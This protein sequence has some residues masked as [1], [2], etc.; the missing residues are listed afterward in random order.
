MAELRTTVVIAPLLDTL[1]RTP[2][3]FPATFLPPSVSELEPKRNDEPSLCLT[4]E[5]MIVFAV[6][7]LI[8]FE[9][10]PVLLI[11]IKNGFESIDPT[12]ESP[13][14]VAESAEIVGTLTIG[15]T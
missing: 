15:Y 10:V 12:I 1:M 6:P 8:T 4:T 5:F 9:K 7:I 3:R 13:A 2:S 11:L 14:V